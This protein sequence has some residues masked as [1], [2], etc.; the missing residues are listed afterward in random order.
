MTTF[1]PAPTL[2]GQSP[3]RG[4]TGRPAGGGGG[5]GAGGGADWADDE[6]HADNEVLM[7]MAAIVRSIA[8][9]PTALPIDVR[10]SRRAIFD[11]LE[12]ISLTCLSY[13]RI[14]TLL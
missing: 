10:N 1:L 6:P 7:P 8:E 4:D 12:V 11:S 3:G 14:L 5:S 13:Q 9:L 2:A